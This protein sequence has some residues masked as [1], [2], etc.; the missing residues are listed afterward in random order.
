ME[1]RR[2]VGPAFTLKGGVVYYLTQ[3]LGGFLEAGYARSV[4]FDSYS[5]KN[6]GGFQ[7]SAGL[8]IT[9]SGKNSD[10]REAW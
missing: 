9:L 7:A 8:R 6:T 5:G 4:Y 3:R 10:I 2:D 1:T